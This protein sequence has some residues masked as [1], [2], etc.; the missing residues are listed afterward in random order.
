MSGLENKRKSDL[1][2]ETKTMTG[3]IFHRSCLEKKRSLSFAPSS[4][5]IDVSEKVESVVE[6]NRSGKNK[7]KKWI[8]NFLFEVGINE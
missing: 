7:L 6:K 3:C 8:C 2:L 4:E 1:E 5:L